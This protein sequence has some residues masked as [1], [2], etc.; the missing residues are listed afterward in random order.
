MVDFLYLKMKLR[1][2]FSRKRGSFR[3]FLIRIQIQD[4]DPDPNPG[5]VT[6]FESGFGSGSESASGIKTNCRPVP[7]PNSDPTLLFRISNTAFP[8]FP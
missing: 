3:Q 4:A 8:S 6:G 5:F 7:D 1:K 2:N